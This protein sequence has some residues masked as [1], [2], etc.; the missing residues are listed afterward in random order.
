MEISH[1]VTRVGIKAQ[2]NIP[3]KGREG[4]SL[5]TRRPGS[6]ARMKPAGKGK[7]EGGWMTVGI[8]LWWQA[9]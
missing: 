8:Q 9:G 6:K 7:G 2:E 5:W 3:G 4:G 1:R